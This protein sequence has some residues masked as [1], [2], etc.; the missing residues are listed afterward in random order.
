M[1]VLHVVM[2]ILQ[3]ELGSD[4]SNRPSGRVGGPGIESAD[5]AIL[6]L[7]A[8]HTTAETSHEMESVANST[9]LGCQLAQCPLSILCFN[10]FS[11]HLLL[12]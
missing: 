6:R 5:L 2:Y 3:E 9:T 4:V 11:S 8:V 10:L 1:I 7:A 12:D